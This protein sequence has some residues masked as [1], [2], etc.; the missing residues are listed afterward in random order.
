MFRGANKLMFQF[1][2]FPYFQT[3]ND[4]QLMQN[5]W[6]SVEGLSVDKRM[7]EVRKLLIPTRGQDK[8][9]TRARMRRF[10]LTRATASTLSVGLFYIPLLTE[11][12]GFSSRFVQ[13]RFGRAGFGFGFASAL[14]R[15]LESPLVAMPQ[16]LIV[17]AIY[18]FLG[19]SGHEDEEEK[20]DDA[21]RDTFRF[22][23]PYFLN[24]WWEMFQ[25]E[26]AV[27]RAEHIMHYIPGVSDA[28]DAIIGAYKA[29]QR[30][31]D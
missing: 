20:Y 5:W 9:E 29:T 14:S 22:F 17:M 25:K 21:S 6:R 19:L 26:E 27:D 24:V 30:A 2:Q 15:G 13:K 31:I 10:L 3:K 8:S 1:K 7:N 12:V 16:R 23:V 11:I 18:T 4:W 28:S